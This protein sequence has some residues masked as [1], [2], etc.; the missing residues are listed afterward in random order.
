MSSADVVIESLHTGHEQLAGLVDDLSEQ[1]LTTPTEIGEWTVAQVLSHLGSGAVIFRKTLGAAL[2][3]KPDP[4]PQSNT[5]I[6]AEWDAKTPV[7]QWRDFLA[8]DQELLDGIDKIPEPTRESMR[9]D[10][11]LPEPADLATTLR[12]RL[13]EFALHSWDVRAFLDDEAVVEASAVPLLL[14]LMPMFLGFLA[15]PEHLG[16]AVT[17]R[18]DLSDPSHRFGLE[19]APEGARVTDVPEQ[20][21]GTLA[22]PAEAWLR[23]TTGRLRREHTPEARISIDGPVTLAD[24]RRVFPGF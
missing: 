12:L 4:G 1:Q 8:A 21:A 3:G 15:K 20:P 16:R 18:I 24:L 7:E 5:A 19:L 17:L 11:F 2:T 22:L 10:S 6:W 9:I 23:L 14:D 13:N